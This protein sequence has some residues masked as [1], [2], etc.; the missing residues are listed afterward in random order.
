MAYLPEEKGWGPGVFQI[1]LDTPW[2]GGPEGNCNKQALEIIRRLNWLKDYAGE[3]EAA[4]GGYEKLGDRLDYFSGLDL[5]NIAAQR[6]YS[7]T[8]LI[9]NRGVISGCT[10]TKSATAIRNISLA[11][12]IFFMDGLELSCPAAVNVALIP[13]NN[14]AAVAYCYAYLYLDGAGAAHFSTTPLGG[15]V[16]DGGLPLYRFSIPAGNDGDTDPYLSQVTMTDLRRMEAGYPIQVNSA[17][18]T[19]VALPEPLGDS[20]YSVVIEIIEA[21]GG[22]NQRASVYPGEKAANGFKLFVEGSLDAVRVRWTVLKLI[23]AEE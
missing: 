16:P 9:T 2:V 19:S 4:R 23:Q 14:G 22:W 7:G 1:E 11:A 20:D 18:F 13:A 3:V 17:A 12:G 21:K 5:G 8:T 6:V 15:A 10:V